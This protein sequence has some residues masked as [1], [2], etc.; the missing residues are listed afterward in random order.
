MA[1]TSSIKP[2][3]KR[4]D[5]QRLQVAKCPHVFSLPPLRSNFSLFQSNHNLGVTVSPI[6]KRS[7][8]KVCKAV[9]KALA[10]LGSLETQHGSWPPELA[11]LQKQ[12]Q[13]FTRKWVRKRK[14]TK[15]TYVQICVYRFVFLCVYVYLYTCKLYPFMPAFCGDKEREMSIVWPKVE[16]FTSSPT[17]N[18]VF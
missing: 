9:A 17:S 7:C 5:L 18:A 11:H 13:S 15:D 12:R 2:H 6:T 14:Q 10:E 16:L 1:P 3:K 8:C 4:L